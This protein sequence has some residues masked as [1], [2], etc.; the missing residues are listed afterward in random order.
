VGANAPLVA[1][2]DLGNSS[3]V[4]KRISVLVLD[5]NFS[6]LAVCTFWI[7]ANTPL[8]TYQMKTHTTQAWANASI[9]FYAASAGSNGGYYR[10]DNVSMHYLPLPVAGPGADARTECVDP[11]APVPPGGPDSGDLLVNGDFGTGSLTPWGTFGTITWQI[12]G[13]IFEFIKPT[14]TPPAGVVLQPTGQAMTANQLISATFQLGNSSG[15]RKRV[16]VLLHDNDFSDLSACTF[17]LAPGQPLSTYTYKAFATKA[18][19]NA[20]LSVYPATVGAQQWMQLDN[21]TLKRTP[22]A[23]N[24]G[25]ECIEP[26]GSSLTGSATTTGNGRN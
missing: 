25:A 19:T 11:T 23:T 24:L 13:G 1:Q 22:A 10:L 8:T 21:A 14:S 17:W 6:D 15:V 16:T 26:G 3:S 12:S 9:Y 4:R 5:S 2:F 18:W 20:T 7:P